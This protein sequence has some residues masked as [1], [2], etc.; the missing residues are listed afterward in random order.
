MRRRIWSEQLNL[1]KW[2]LLPD[3]LQTLCQCTN[4]AVRSDWKNYFSFL[5]HASFI[6][7][8]LQVSYSVQSA[9]VLQLRDVWSIG[10]VLLAHFDLAA[11]QMACVMAWMLRPLMTYERICAKRFACRTFPKSMFPVSMW[12]SLYM[13]VN[14]ARL[15]SPVTV[16]LEVLTPCFCELIS[17]G[18]SY[19]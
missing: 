13:W 7:V 12:T 5:Y 3:T 14:K 11:V 10:H 6:I 1:C 15:V 2:L 9:H 8:N 16:C 4:L 18:N 17:C 19:F